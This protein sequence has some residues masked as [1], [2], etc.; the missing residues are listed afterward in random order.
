MQ[1]FMAL[2]KLERT[3]PQSSIR[4]VNRQAPHLGGPLINGEVSL[5]LHHNT[6]N[7]HYYYALYQSFPRLVELIVVVAQLPN[8]YHVRNRRVPIVV[9]QR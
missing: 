5:Y 8:I 9:T 1:G 2:L 6:A 7:F 3:R 4:Y